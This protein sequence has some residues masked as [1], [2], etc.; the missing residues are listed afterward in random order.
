VINFNIHLDIFYTLLSHGA[1]VRYIHSCVFCTNKKC[2]LPVCS[3]CNKAGIDIVLLYSASDL[4]I[5]RKC[6]I[7]TLSN[8]MS[9][10]RV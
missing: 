7:D 3:Q 2:D 9:V 6:I 8:K 4:K 5:L 1:E 10:E